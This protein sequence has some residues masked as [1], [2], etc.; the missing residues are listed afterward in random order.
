M[1]GGPEGGSGAPVNEPGPASAFEDR[2]QLLFEQSPAGL[3]HYDRELRLTE[4]NRSLVSILRSSRERLVGLDLALREDAR[5]VP[6][7]RSVA[8]RR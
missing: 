4:C 6:E 5:G 1:N 3:F 2:Y 7:R 8:P